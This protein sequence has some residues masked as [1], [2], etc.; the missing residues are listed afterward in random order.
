MR[1]LD[2]ARV[3]IVDDELDIRFPLTRI[4]AFEGYEAEEAASGK[5]ALTLLEQKRYDLMVLDMH[6]PGLSGVEVMEYIH[7]HYPDWL[8]I[9]LTGQTTL[10]STT[11]AIEIDAVV[12]YLIKP[13][14]TDEFVS[15]IHEAL[16]K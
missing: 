14:T 5:A 15:A 6:M 4:L 9:V 16:K 3:L 10:E 7:H 13:A 2:K 12:N 8:V 11:A 1:S